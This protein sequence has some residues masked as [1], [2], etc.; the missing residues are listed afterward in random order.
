MFSGSVWEERLCCS[1]GSERYACECEGAR[2][3]RDRR[4]SRAHVCVCAAWQGARTTACSKPLP[5]T[6]RSSTPSSL[7]MTEAHVCHPS[8]VYHLSYFT[9]SLILNFFSHTFIRH[10]PCHVC[11]KLPL[12]LSPAQR[13]PL[14]VC[15]FFYNGTLFM[16]ASASLAASLLE[17]DA[18]C[19]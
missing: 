2:Q 14:P 3:G 4:Q 19:K 18:P 16:H 13:S 6:S 9:S 5:T 17:R 12:R 15:A 7:S 11:L 8:A 1:G 10:V